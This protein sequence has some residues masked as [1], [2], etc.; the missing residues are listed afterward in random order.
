MGAGGQEQMGHGLNRLLDITEQH[1]GLGPWSRGAAIGN[2]DKFCQ[3]NHSFPIPPFGQSQHHLPLPTKGIGSAWPGQGRDPLLTSSRFS[4]VPSQPPQPRAGSAQISSVQGHLRS[5]TKPLCPAHTPTAG[6]Q[7][8]SSACWVQLA[9][10]ES[11]TWI[12][13]LFSHLHKG[14]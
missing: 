6:Q 3:V 10:T 9:A 7:A 4:A 5:P 13:S 12:T 11:C 1:S 8:E 2:R 14:H